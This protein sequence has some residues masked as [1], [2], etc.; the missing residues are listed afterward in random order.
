MYVT[1]EGI[2]TAGKSTQIEALRKLFTQAVFTKEPGGTDIG[3]TIRSMILNG[4]LK[5]KH[6]E[7]FMFLADR[8]EHTHKVIVPNLN[9]LIISD[10]SCVSGVAYATVQNVCDTDTLVQL[11]R[12]AT[13]NHLPQHVFILVLTPEELIYRLSQKEHDAIES[14][15]IEYLLSIQNALIAS[16]HSLGIQTHV[17]D[18]SQSIDTITL[19]IANLIKGAL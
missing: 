2:D 19:E 10:R 12:L 1:I 18:A 9:K 17:I 3:Q 13:D 8:A 14:R 16:A 11:N 6:A 4:E 15:G 5:N 7:M